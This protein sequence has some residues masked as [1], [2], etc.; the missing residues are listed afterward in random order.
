MP[1][2]ELEFHSKDARL[3]GTLWS[4][5]AAGRRPGIVMVGGSGPSDRD[6]DTLFPPIREHLVRAGLAVLCYD[7]RGV[8]RSSGSWLAAGYDELAGDASAAV[9]ALRGQPEVDPAA[10]G[11]FGH[12]EGG[13]VVLHAAA[14]RTDLSFVVTNAGPGVG[15]AAQERWAM[16]QAMRADGVAESDIEDCRAVYDRLVRD[17]RRGTSYAEVSSWLDTEPAWRLISRYG[18]ALDPP[19]WR[20]IT[21]VIGHDPAPDRER[22]ACPHLA[23]FGGADSVVPVEQSA[24]AFAAAAGRSG[25][26]G[27]SGRAGL[28]IE[29]FLGADHRIRVDGGTR[30]ADGYLDTLTRWILAALRPAPRDEVL[31]VPASGA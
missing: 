22:L 10:V 19:T 29:V 18:P 14:G 25:F 6:N 23:I 4:S 28:T 8:G 15:P 21:L 12:S 5:E 20:F 17:G 13:W 1:S 16:A 24:A 27:R 2:R 31:A 26:A 30:F 7:K 11:L 9:D 3:S